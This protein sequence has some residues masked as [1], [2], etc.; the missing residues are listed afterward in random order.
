MGVPPACH[1]PHPAILVKR[2]VTWDDRMLDC[3]VDD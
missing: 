1:V 2:L 3:G